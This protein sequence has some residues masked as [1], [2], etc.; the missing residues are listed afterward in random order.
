M[1][2]FPFGLNIRIAIAMLGA[3]SLVSCSGGGGDSGTTTPASS[4]PAPAATQA[5][6]SELVDTF[7]STLTAAQ[8]VPQRS[9]AA[10]AAGTVVI[11]PAT[12]LMT[13]TLTTTGIAG[14]AADIQQAP[15]GLNG[16]IVFPLTETSR[17]SGVW[18]ARAVLTEAQ[19]N[20]FRA[21]DF[22][23]NVRSTNFGEGE[24]RGQILS[25]QPGTTPATS[26]STGTGTSANTGTTSV[27]AGLNPFVTSTGT[28]LTALR[29]SQEVPPNT[30]VA[31]GSGTVLVN[32]ANGQL[33][34]GVTTSGIAGTSAHIHEAPQGV[35]GPIIF[36]LAESVAGSGVWT[37]SVVLTEAQLASL[38]AGN[39]YFNVHSA[40]FPNGEIRG[41]ILPQ[42]ISLEFVTG[43]AGRPGATN[44]TGTGLTGTGTGITGTGTTGTGTTGTGMTGTGL[45]GTGT[46]GS[47]L[48]GTGVTGTGTGLTGTGTGITG[49]GTGLT[50]IGTG[51]TGTGTGITGT[52]TG[53]TGTGTGLTGTGTGIT[54]TGLTGTTAT[55]ATGAGLPGTGTTGID[56][57]VG[58][59]F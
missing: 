40:A 30:S 46:T 54:G 36:P 33:I 35:N 13:A 53:L 59:R 6:V 17:G 56:T 49:T 45:T 50:G 41:Q 12:R 20:A 18:T 7:A 39:F 21:G 42:T 32:P 15:A 48:T 58:L 55:G 52:G 10:T 1:K 27:G 51:I 38:Q 16:P 25:Q 4:S 43:A 34:A 31:L 23:F 19:H 3:L 44:G 8:V 5:A 47:G 28:F 29:G 2:S 11:Q 24:I 9:S 57:S 26:T 22:Y 14:T 37:T